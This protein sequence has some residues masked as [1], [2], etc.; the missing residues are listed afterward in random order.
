MHACKQICTDIWVAPVNHGV[1]GPASPYWV[2]VVR[3]ARVQDGWSVPR[4]P[5]TLG[6]LWG[7][8]RCLESK[9]LVPGNPPGMGLQTPLGVRST[10]PGWAFWPLVSAQCLPRTVVTDTNGFWPAGPWL[11]TTL[12]NTQGYMVPKAF[13]S[14]SR[15]HNSCFFCY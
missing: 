2:E 6:S 3:Q 10:G 11:E 5:V 8:W 4:L 1:H 15:E 7:R 12:S 13:F 9:P 14:L